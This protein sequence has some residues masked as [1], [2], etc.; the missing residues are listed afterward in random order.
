[1]FSHSFFVAH[2]SKILQ[3][4]FVFHW[5]RY[6]VGDWSICSTTCGTGFEARSVVC[7]T[8]SEDDC[9]NDGLTKP[10]DTQAC[11]IEDCGNKKNSFF[12]FLWKIFNVLFCLFPNCVKRFLQTCGVRYVEK[13]SLTN[14]KKFKVSTQAK[15]VLTWRKNFF[16]TTLLPFF[17]LLQDYISSWAPSAAPSSFPSPS[18][19]FN[20]SCKREA[21]VC[22]FFKVDRRSI[23]CFCP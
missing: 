7:T 16:L 2:K 17:P 1:M 10:D 8:G 14:G 21:F 13:T 19:L 11:S 15:F 5:V 18:N 4:V 3:V 6:L 23:W 22:F 9:V 20:F 12:F